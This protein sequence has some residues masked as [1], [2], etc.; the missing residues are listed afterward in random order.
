MNELRQEF[1]EL[2]QISE[3]INY[4]HN[5]ILS[6]NGVEYYCD[7]DSVQGRSNAKFVNGAWWA[8]QEQHKKYEKINE[9]TAAQGES[10]KI[11][12]QERIKLLKQV[13]AYQKMLEMQK[14]FDEANGIVDSIGMR[15]G[16]Y[17][18]PMKYEVAGVVAE[19]ELHHGEYLID[20]STLDKPQQSI[21]VTLDDDKIKEIFMVNS[22]ELHNNR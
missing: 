14:A 9:Y 19:K 4:W 3:K 1:E 2:P 6:F 8:Y 12:N 16:G 13:E 17:F 20:T 10:I 21:I 5:R 7:R 11:L 22:N 18:E 15:W